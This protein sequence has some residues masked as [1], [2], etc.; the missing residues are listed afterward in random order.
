MENS[1]IGLTPPLPPFFGQNNGKFCKILI[2]A[3]KSGLVLN[4]NVFFFNM[5]FDI[6]DLPRPPL[7]IREFSIIFLF[8]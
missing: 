7:Q 6:A 8:F 1:I 3:S 4:Q 2:I 5:E